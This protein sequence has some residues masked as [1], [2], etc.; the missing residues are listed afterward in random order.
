MALPR[1]RSRL[2]HRRGCPISTTAG[3]LTWP[4]IHRSEVSGRRAPGDAT[5]SSRHA[6]LGVCADQRGDLGRMVGDQLQFGPLATVAVGCH[7]GLGDR[8][9]VPGL[10]GVSPAWRSSRVR[11]RREPTRTRDGLRSSPRR[12]LRW[13]RFEAWT[14]FADAGNAVSDLGSDSDETTVV[15]AYGGDMTLAGH[16]RV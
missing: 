15:A 4:I 11:S 2:Q 16:H 1:R 7:G 13:F 8:S 6:P 10:G 14:V 9:R 3:T 5:A 12:A